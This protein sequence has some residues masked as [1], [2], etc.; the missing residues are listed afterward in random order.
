MTPL[1]AACTH[2]AHLA[3]TALVLVSVPLVII[4]PGMIVY[5]FATQNGAKVNAVDGEGNTPLHVCCRHGAAFIV[6]ILVEN[7]AIIE[8]QV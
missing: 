2:G 1:I 4:P 3:V 5:C 6:Q 7:D 8:I